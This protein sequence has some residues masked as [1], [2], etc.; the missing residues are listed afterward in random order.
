MEQISKEELDRNSV[1]ILYLGFPMKMYDVN[2]ETIIHGFW[3]WITD[4]IPEPLFNGGSHWTF[5]KYK[6][7]YWKALWRF[8]N[9]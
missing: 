9:G 3:S 4:F 2:G 8:L 5:I 7:S 1:K 6:G